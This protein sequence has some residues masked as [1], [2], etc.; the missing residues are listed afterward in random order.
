[1]PL[2]NDYQQFLDGL[3]SEKFSRLLPS[4]SHVLQ[5]Y[6]SDF[7]DRNDVAIELPTGAGKT[8]ISL[9]IAEDWRRDR[10]KVVILSG[11]KTL[12]RQMSDEADELGIPSV[13]ME[14]GASSIPARDRRSYQRAGQVAIMNYWVYFNQSPVIDP[15]D[16]VIMDDAHLAEH[17]LDSL[18]SLEI[19]KSR[20]SELFNALTDELRL[21]FPEYSVLADARD[22]PTTSTRPPELLSF[23]DQV[24]SN[25]RIGELIESSSAI[26]SDADF[27]FRWGRMR[28][29]LDESNI[30]L[31]TNQIWIRP[32][33]YPLGS[34]AHYE[35]STQRLYMSATIG[36]PSDLSRRLGVRSIE[37]IPVPDEYRESSSGRRLVVMN[38]IGEDI[39]GEKLTDVIKSA[40]RIQPKS[41]WLCS[42]TAEAIKFQSGFTTWL[43][44]NQFQTHQTWLLTSHG[45]EI[46]SF[47]RSA[48]GHLFVGGRFDGMDF[49]ADECRFVVVPSLP[50]AIN[51]QEEF[52]SAYLRDSGFM[53]SR[54]NQRIVQALGRCNRSPDDFAVYLLADKRFATHFGRES[55]RA[56]LTRN[57]ISEID[58]AQDWAE[59]SGEELA[60]RVSSFLSGDFSQ[61]DDEV[62][63]RLEDVPASEVA[64]SSDDV[65]NREVVAWT[66]LFNSHNYDVAARNF[67]HCS[68]VARES[69]QI[70]MGAL[71]KWYWAKAEHLRAISGEA[72]AH[73]RSL[74]LM[75][76]AISR[77][78]QSAWFNHMRASLNRARSGA[79]RID[80]ITNDEYASA[81]IQAFDDFLEIEGDRGPRYERTCQRKFGLLASDNHAQFQ[82]GL[83]FTGK[84][85]GFSSDRPRH[86]AAADCRWRGIFGNTREM[87]T[88]EAKI[89]HT[90]NAI[91]ASDLGQAHNQNSRAISEFGDRGYTVASVITT[92]MTEFESGADSSAGSIK[93]ITKEAVQD[94]A[95]II[96]G[97][98]TTYRGGWSLDNISDRRS[99][100]D[101]L[102]LSLPSSGWLLRA[103]E[104]ENR[105]IDSSTLLQEWNDR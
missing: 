32:Y 18:Y 98:L 72:G 68:E 4:Q 66:A 45:D 82:E 102:R 93:V 29:S 88:F 44:A 42:S 64:P 56:G 35:Q 80:S 67:Q 77:G 73:D 28:R 12:A 58:M 84:L 19:S 92:H 51:T 6:S 47:R 100:A 38:E 22:A 31:S 27:R 61:F 79:P 39:T 23:V 96:R 53:K 41:L 71:Q 74:E 86:N 3:Q 57:I 15:A 24:S 54:L 26:Q 95:N 8:L 97:L 81:V 20:H 21:K 17:C 76:E 90:G 16:L 1:M 37:K 91:S 40:M 99:A 89:E 11:N 48:A 10:K 62:R 83:E 14:G 101:R 7:S 49:D 9:L 33:I 75:N 34:N 60:R 30:Y 46:D 103:I 25:D 104:N 63:D 5:D 50:R 69:N 59:L 13:L 105:F 70:E 2:S 55:N 94:L 43:E 36:E 78:G 65:A 52:L 85:L 87:F